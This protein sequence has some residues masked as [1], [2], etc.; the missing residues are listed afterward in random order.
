[1]NTTTLHPVIARSQEDYRSEIV[2][3]DE[4]K[5]KNLVFSD[6]DKN[7]L[8]SN[9]IEAL[10]NKSLQESI[11]FLLGLNSINYQ[12]WSVEPEVG[13][14]RYQ[15]NGKV[16]A[17]AMFE[18]FEKFYSALQN[19]E[20]SLDKLSLNDIDTYWGAIPE[21][22]QRVQILK[23]SCSLVGIT[24]AV[25][26][27]INHIENRK[28][29]DIETAAQL[30]N[31]L[32]QSYED[33]YFKKIQLALYEIAHCAQLKGYPETECDI[34]V[35]ADYQIPKVLEGMGVLKYSPD[36]IKKIEAGILIKSDSVEEKAIRAATILACEKIS[37][38]HSISIP[39]LDR[40]LWLSRNKFSTK[41]HLTKTPKY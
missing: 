5:I 40:Q 41:F 11:A 17:I 10:Q 38:Q 6:N 14:V 32:P 23:E 25:D 15:N 33:P 39:A 4:D 35:A 8:A 30:V 21:P 29:L 27:I 9:E 22:E 2:A 7:I 36:L 19:G 13:F 3:I 12:F 26:L 28:M 18:G 1:M 20:V 31:I 24:P 16:G 37:K 34:T